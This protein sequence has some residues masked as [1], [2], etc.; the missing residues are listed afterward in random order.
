MELKITE[1]FRSAAPMDFSAS[2]AEIGTDAGRAT[3][4]AAWEES[5]DTVILDD[6]EK[7]DAFRRFVRDSGG[8]TDEEIKAWS[9]TELNALCIQWIAGDMREPVGFELGA[10]STDEDWAEYQRQAEQGQVAGRLFKGTDSEIYF[11]IGS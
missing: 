7:R 9:D 10:D 4:A 8:W 2:V 11:Y 3:W 6:E 5:R 1:F